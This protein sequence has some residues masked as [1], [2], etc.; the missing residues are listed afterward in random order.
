MAAAENG[1]LELAATGDP[2]VDRP[3]ATSPARWRQ[4]AATYNQAAPQGDDDRSA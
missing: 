3:A 2:R 4:A 1:L